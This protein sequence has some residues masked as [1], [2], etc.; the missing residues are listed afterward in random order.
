MPLPPGTHLG[1]YE[2]L[3]PLG[4][5]GMGEVYRA[6]DTRLGRDVAVKI[7]PPAVADNPAALA[8]FERE[9][10][11]V[12]AL[13][14][15][16]ILTLHD[17]SRTNGTTYAVMELLAGETLRARLAPGALPVRK[18]VEI[19][20]A[21]ARGLAAAHDRHIAHRDLKPENIFITTDGSVK[22]LDFGLA[23]QLDGP[24]PDLTASPTHVAGTEPGVVLGTVGYMSPEQ[25]RGE[26]GD[27]RSDVFALGAVLYE[28]LTG[29]RA[30]QRET[31]AETMTA[32][33]KEDPADP[34]ASAIQV[35]PGVMRIVRRC[36][37]KRPEE[38]FQSTRDL[39][40]A[41]ESSLDAS[42]GSGVAMA[43]RVRRPQPGVLLLAGGL[44]LGAALGW[45]ATR[46]WT[47]S[48]PA[49]SAPRYTRL[50]NERGTIRGA[51]FTPDGQSV[52]Y[53]AAWEGNPLR[54]FMT[55]TDA[56]AS[57][58]LSIPDAHL[59]AV[60]KSGEM[61]VS[62]GHAFEG[63]MGVGTL[64]TSSVLGNAPRVL[65]EGVREADWTPDGTQMAVVRPVGTV[66]QLE[67]PI[68]KVLY[69]TSGYIS[70]VRFSPKGDLIAFAD[71]PGVG[72]D[73][74]LVAVI[75]RAGQR[76]TLTTAYN[77]LRG[78]AWSPDGSEIWH[79]V[80]G[81]EVGI[82]A[83]T[84]KGERR[85]VL[86]APSR[87]TLLDVAADG[88]A[89][90]AQENP[91][92]RV[93]ALMAGDTA[94]ED[95][96]FKPDSSSQWISEDGT[97]LTISDQSTPNYTAYL[98]RKGGSL[99]VLGDGQPY[100]MSSDGRWVV[101]IPISGASL[102]VHSSGG[103]HTRELPNSHRLSIIAVQWLPDSHHL[104]MFAQPPGEP[105]RGYV[106]DIDGGDPKAFTPQGARIGTPRWWS[107]V[108]SPDGSR[109]VGRNSDGVPT[110]YRLSDG[111]PETVPG[112][113]ADDVPVQWCDDG[114]SLFIARGRTAPWAV[115]RMD[116]VTGRRTP[117]MEVSAREKAG[118]RLS[119]LSMSR[120]GRYY[121]H[122]FSRLLSDLYLV[123]G[124]K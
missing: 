114:R 102:L 109:V 62:L 99:M 94:P 120:N 24:A 67:S 29:R 88:R 73:T 98:L 116:V 115:E 106:Q 71:H 12:A 72:D 26:G 18:A 25:V 41:L 104:V 40:F 2:I 33:L 51:R 60:S 48:P 87:L 112:I 16:N 10:R 20:S 11:A 80:S 15:P 124:L 31:A 19:A 38:R 89:L 107:F 83:V 69:K 46:R 14:H 1:P 39:A 30:F 122:S 123:D 64:A 82:Y 54:V 95:V 96:T 68:G 105:I 9:A 84:V 118:L 110:L 81:P 7:V 56:T 70:D 34:S 76:R 36:L 121:V 86:S 3:A 93:E 111:Q 65:L 47:P 113:Q 77:S 75:D 4:A 59:F 8:R 78:L 53:S 90:I 57:V 92:R 49:T 103:G 63:W 44:V 79:S 6:H 74:G 108:V 43:E 23:R 100:G 85:V 28:M 61:A 119:L 32:I 27:Q 13:S 101:S 58:R 117:I 50:T 21:V 91:E 97:S 55:R 17:F 66:D 37:E 22:I 35:P 5:G 45:L 42:S 52:V